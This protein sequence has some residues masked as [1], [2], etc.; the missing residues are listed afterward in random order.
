[1]TTTRTKPKPGTVTFIG[2]GPGDPGLLTV[3][4]TEA[5]AAADVVVLSRPH[6]DC[7]LAHAADGVEIIDTTCTERRREQGRARSR[8]GGQAGRTRVLRRPDRA[9]RIR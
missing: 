9:V 8:E 3:R 1:M 2:G 4:A 6:L 7:V 5:L